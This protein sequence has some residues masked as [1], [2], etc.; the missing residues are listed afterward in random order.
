M[1]KK[2][3]NNRRKIAKKAIISLFSLLLT[4]FSLFPMN[5]LRSNLRKAEFSRN[6]L[7]LLIHRSLHERY[8]RSQDIILRSSNFAAYPLYSGLNSRSFL[9]HSALNHTRQVP[10]FV[11]GTAAKTFGVNY[12][13][14]SSLLSGIAAGFAT[15]K[16]DAVATQTTIYG[17]DKNSTQEECI[18]T[19]QEIV[20]QELTYEERRAKAQEIKEAIDALLLHCF[21]KDY[22]SG[23]NK[24]IQFAQTVD[25][26]LE[27]IK[28][29]ENL[30]DECEDVF[31]LNK[32]ET[33]PQVQAQTVIKL[34][35]DVRDENSIKN[36]SDKLYDLFYLLPQELQNDWKR[37]GIRLY[38]RLKTGHPGTNPTYI[39]DMNIFEKKE[40]PELR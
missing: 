34:L 13:L 24:N 11:V 2:M 1:E 37:L 40:Y 6:S 8:T 19:K 27:K 14:G 30:I 10:V 31:F 22:W 36:I 29:F 28:G 33:W 26:C 7:N 38:Y 32:P 35:L 4:C 3:V 18:E 5:S 39:Y 9:K 25:L 12:F 21:G 20:S 23:E 15:Q 17:A 16:D